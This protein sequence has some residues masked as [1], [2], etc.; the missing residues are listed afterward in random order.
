MTDDI[1]IKYINNT[2]NTDFEVMVFTKNYSTRTPKVYYVAWQVLRGQTSV[3]FK[4][5][6]SISV[7]ATY[8]SSGLQVVAGPFG[9]DLGSSWRITQDKPVD[10]AVLKQSKAKKSSKCNMYS[11]VIYKIPLL[12]A[13]ERI[14]S[15]VAVKKFIRILCI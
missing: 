4:Y 6:V 9:S 1:P 10:T 8:Y 13:L 5:P 2:R 3:E 12:V 15:F 14:H 11:S 7:G